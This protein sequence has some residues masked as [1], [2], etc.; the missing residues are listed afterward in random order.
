MKQT[1]GKVKAE[2][3]KA[4][5]YRKTAF[6]IIILLGIVSMFG[7]IAY[8]GAR[9]ISGPFLATLGASAVMVG[10]VTGAGEF[11]GYGL[12][13]VSGYFADRTKAYWTLTFLGY[14]LIGAIPL[15]A[16]AGNWPLAAVLLILERIGK[17]VRSPARDTI[18]SFSAKNVGR[19]WG[20]ALHEALDQV[21]AIIGPLI[22]SLALITSGGYRQGFIILWIPVVL[23]VVALTV[24]NRKA[25]APERLETRIEAGKQ[26][27][28][29][30]L[31]RIFWLYAIF[32]LLTGTGFASFQLMAY[33]VK[34]QAIIADAQIPILYAI[35]MGVDA[36]VALIIGKTYDKWGLI[37]LAVIP[38]LTLPIP[39]LGF[40]HTYGLILL[41]IILWGSVMGTHETIM[42]AAIADLVPVERR[43]SAYGIF[44]TFYGLSLFV[45]GSVM[46]LLYDFSISYLIIFVAVME[47]LAIPSLF[48]IKRSS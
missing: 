2:Q 47:L 29:T 42:R 12:R 6:Q 16:F 35:A 38:A 26:N 1:E 34:T 4:S 41:A 46:G 11:L 3:L 19:G 36:V 45:G 48:V 7:D 22:L 21:G 8:E 27:V 23:C 17:A 43:G 30:G 14:G 20:F 15:L 33:H 25:P 28:K 9:S 37:V 40:S 24:A 44:N 31:G 18:I 39:F 32:V 5:S 10:T 13:L